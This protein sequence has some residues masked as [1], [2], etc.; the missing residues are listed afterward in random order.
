MQQYYTLEEAASKL[1]LSP[2]EL[3]Q[4]AKSKKIRAFQD[5][6]SWRFRTQD[7]EE[8]ARKRG[9]GSDPE[10]QIGESSSASKAPS[11]V[12]KRPSKLGK[13]KPADEDALA[14]D[15]D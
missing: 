5:K 3:R 1:M 9:V 4:M 15:F 8:E 6:G 14:V 2:D 13:Q 10:V 12:S 7:V 11:S